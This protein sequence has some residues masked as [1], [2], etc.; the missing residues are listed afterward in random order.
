VAQLNVQQQMHPKIS[1][2]IQM[3]LYPC[4]IDH[5]TTMNL[6][7]VIGMQRNVFWLDH[8]NMEEVPNANY[9]KKSHSN[10]WEV[11]MTHSFVCHIIWQGIY[12]SSNIAVLTPYTG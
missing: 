3:T 8:E 6:P 7:D 9:Y 4:L 10:D 1:T 5:E 11:D 2:L 12:S